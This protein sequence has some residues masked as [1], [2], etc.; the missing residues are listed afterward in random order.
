MDCRPPQPVLTAPSRAGRTTRRRKASRQVWSS[1][2]ITLVFDFGFVL[3]QS[4]FRLSTTP[5]PNQ[6]HLVSCQ[7]FGAGSIFPGSCL[8][9]CAQQFCSRKDCRWFCN[10][11]RTCTRAHSTSG[12]KRFFRASSSS[13]TKSP[14]PAVQREVLI[15]SRAGDAD[16]NVTDSRER[17][18]TACVRAWCLFECYFPCDLIQFLSSE[19]DII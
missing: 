10:G 13:S 5:E 7:C 2:V 18:K 3:A 16:L 9:A 6:S 19:S 14:G 4:N 11:S 1:S 15:G 12:R 17:C 8:S